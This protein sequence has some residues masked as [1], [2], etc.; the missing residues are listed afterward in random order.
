[1]ASRAVPAH[2]CISAPVTVILPLT[3]WPLAEEA[4]N[5]ENAMAARYRFVFIHRSPCCNLTPGMK[6]VEFIVGIDDRGQRF[7]NGPELV[8]GNHKV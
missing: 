8:T 3:I 1:M 5:S 2:Q 7:A 6:L 4:A